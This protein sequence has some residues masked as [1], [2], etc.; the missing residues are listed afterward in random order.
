MMVMV[1][2]GG[3]VYLNHPDFAAGAAAV[4]A[5]LAGTESNLHSQLAAPVALGQMLPIGVKGAFCAIMI[6]GMLAN[7]SSMMHSFG[8]VFV[9]DV[10][11]PFRKKPLSE[12]QNMRWLRWSI[13]GV[14][15]FAFVFS[16]LFQQVDFIVM[17]Q[18]VTSAVYMAGAGAVIIGGLYW[19]RGTVAAAWAAMV[20]GSSLALG[21]LLIQQVWK[22]VHP[23]LVE[24]ARAISLPE[25]AAYLMLHP[26]KLPIPGHIISLSA[27]LLATVVYLSVSL[28]GRK[29]TH[30]MEKL[31]NR[32]AY[33]VEAQKEGDSSQGP[34]RFRWSSLI[35]IDPQFTRTD[36][37]IAGF[38]FFWGIWWAA[39]ALGITAWN[40]FFSR[41]PAEWF[42]NYEG[43]RAI[44]I[45]GFF[46][47]L[48]TVWFTIGTARD[49]WTALKILKSGK[50]PDDG[51]PEAAGTHANLP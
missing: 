48:T 8:S 21:A 9:Q 35:G 47:L 19:K 46:G 23:H 32:G 43:F 34:R 45:G 41:W 14:A 31:L 13:F 30:D 17:F 1:G 10:L 44:I 24:A 3:L 11:L 27:A 29:S 28:L 15:V 33:R 7:D 4:H 12:K 6:W 5:A 37:F 25:A 22:D 20:S 38:M 2:L 36:R 42:A 39:L 51:I 26:E 18:I 50:R 49:L 40:A 16:A